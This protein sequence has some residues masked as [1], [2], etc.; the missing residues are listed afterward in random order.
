MFEQLG[1]P[2]VVLCTEPFAV[3]AQNIARTLGCADYPFVLLQHPL[4]SK[5]QAQI[6]EMAAHA[7]HQAVEILSGA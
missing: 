7:Y 2:A 3:T 1:K 6:E 4:G 5:T